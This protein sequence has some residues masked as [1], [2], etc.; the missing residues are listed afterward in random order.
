M[1]GHT[2][3]LALHV[4]RPTRGSD[5]QRFVRELSRIAGVIRVSPIGRFSRLLMIAYD[6]QLAGAATFVEHA[7]R[8]WGVA[9]IVRLRAT[10]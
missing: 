8:N 3:H 5:L 4:A 6:P 9:Q 7:R 2:L 10:A 1:L